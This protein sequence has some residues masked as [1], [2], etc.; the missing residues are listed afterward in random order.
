MSPSYRCYSLYLVQGLVTDI[1][2]S[3]EV[4]LIFDKKMQYLCKIS[5]TNEGSHPLLQYSTTSTDYRLQ[6]GPKRGAR[7]Q[8]QPKLHKHQPSDLR[9]MGP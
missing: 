3:H 6:I 4:S 9:S 8:S 1:I 2:Y 7:E 5:M